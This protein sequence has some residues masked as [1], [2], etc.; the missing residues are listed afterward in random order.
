MRLGRPWR[1][2]RWPR[3]KAAY[4]P[5]ASDGR[6]MDSRFVARFPAQNCGQDEWTIG[7][8]SCMASC[9]EVDT[10][11]S[12]MKMLQP[13]RTIRMRRHGAETCVQA[14][15]RPRQSIGTAGAA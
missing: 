11:I 9:E 1:P 12:V 13:A 14:T 8:E 6:S 5:L 4:P 10:T 2:I 3:L 7:Q 15:A